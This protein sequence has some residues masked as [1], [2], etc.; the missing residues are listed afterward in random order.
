M[1][2]VLWLYN[3]QILYFVVSA[4]AHHSS[5]PLFHM[6]ILDRVI[7]PLVPVFMSFVWIGENTSLTDGCLVLSCPLLSCPVLSCPVFSL[8]ISFLSCLFFFF[9]FFLLLM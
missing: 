8:C 3:E 2:Y 5:V 1:A 9:F 4:C 7:F 6:C